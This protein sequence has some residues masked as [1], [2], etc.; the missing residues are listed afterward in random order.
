MSP[1]EGP[2]GPRAALLEA[3][4][5][6]VRGVLDDRGGLRFVPEHGTADDRLATI[7]AVGRACV[8]WT[9]PLARHELDVAVVRADPGCSELTLRPVGGVERVQ[10]RRAV[11]TRVAVRCAV[12]TSGPEGVTVSPATTVDL[13]AGGA[14]VTVARDAEVGG[15]MP[16]LAVG[17]AVGLV[18][19]LP[20][21]RIAVVATVLDA[22]RRA[23]R[24]TLRLQFVRL[25]PTDATALTG[26]VLRT[27]TRRHR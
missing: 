20:E 4:H 5:V 16:A 8:S 18:L 12:C 17:D 10:R 3:R 21:R 25:R 6:V 7:T 11:R 23:G 22:G 14:A 26:F 1:A 2:L 24:T 13:S 15:T 27:Q 19:Q 9:G